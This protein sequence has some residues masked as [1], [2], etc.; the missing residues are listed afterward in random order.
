M[1][2]EIRMENGGYGYKVFTKEDVKILANSL[3]SNDRYKYRVAVLPDGSTVKLEWKQNFDG[4][5]DDP[6]IKFV[7]S[8]DTFTRSLPIRD[9]NDASSVLRVLSRIADIVMPA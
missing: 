7:I 1:I 4:G 5:Y 2:K 3:I 6:D 9:I 8:T